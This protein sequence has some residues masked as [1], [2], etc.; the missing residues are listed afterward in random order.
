MELRALGFGL[1]VEGLGL[2]SFQSEPYSI[3]SFRYWVQVRQN[4]S[5][6]V[7][8]AEHVLHP[9][10]VNRSGGCLLIHNPLRRVVPWRIPQ[11]II[12]CIE[13]TCTI[14]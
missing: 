14:T 9:E 10:A 7:S 1:R 4:Q 5:F 12:R 13:S 8:Q 3:Y 2:S 11:N 6:K